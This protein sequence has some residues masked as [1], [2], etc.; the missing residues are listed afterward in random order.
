[1][2]KMT[3]RER[4]KLVREKLQKLIERHLAK[5]GI[6]QE[7]LARRCGLSVNRVNKLVN[8]RA[9]IKLED[10]DYLSKDGLVTSPLMPNLWKLARNGATR[11]VK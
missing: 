6:T 9:E 2:Q 8:A 3:E 4:K 11:T 1:M 10:V 5:E 7:E